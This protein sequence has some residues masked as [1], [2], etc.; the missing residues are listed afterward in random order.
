MKKFLALTA[1]VLGLASCQT[2]PEGLDVNVGGEQLVTVNV[3]VPETET[4]ANAGS[5]SAVGAFANGVLG[6]ADD[7][8]TMRYIL[9]VYYK[10]EENSEAKYTASQ[11]RLVEYS[12]GKTV[13]F[14]VRLVPKRNYQ[15][16]VWADVVSD[17]KNDT[18][19]HYNTSDLKNITLKGEWNAMDESR[20]AFTA[21]ELIENYS[22]SSDINITLKR[23]FAKLRVVTTDMKALNNLGIEPT[24]ATVEYKVQHY[25]A[26]NALYGKAISDS[27]NRDIKHENYTIASYGENIAE[28]AD[29]TL[30]SDYFFAENDAVQFELKVYDQNGD[31]IKENA[32]NTDIYV[33]RNYLTTIKGNILT[34][35]N[36]FDVT[37]D[38]VFAGELGEEDGKKFANVDTAE[39]LLDAI[40]KGIENITVED[41]IDLNDLL[42]AGTLA[43]RAT[44]DPS[45]AIKA[46]KKI[47]IDLGGFTLSATSSQTGKNYDMIDVRGTLSIKN[48]TIE[49]KHEGNNMEWN[50]STNVFNV[51]A[52]GVLNLD[53]VTAKN[54]GGSDMAFVAHLNNW[55]E[56]TL[57]VDNSTLESTYVAVRVF[58]SGNDMNNVTIKN[59]TL[60]G[61]SAAFWVHNYTVADFGS[62]AK[63]E[64][65]KALLNLNIY[66]QGNTFIPDVNGIRYGFTNSVRSDACGITKSVSEDGSIV[67]LGTILE[68]AV[69]RQGV[70]GYENSTIKK[71][72]VGEGIA[73]LE[74]RC[75]RKFHALEEVV[76]PAGLTTIG[77]KEKG[78]GD[79]TG[80]GMFQGCENL[81]TIIIPETVTTIDAGSFYGC[82]AL[83][84]INIPSGVTRI[85]ESS[86]RATGLKNIVFHEGV[87]YFG[88]QAFR[89]CENLEEIYINAPS[90]TIESNTFLNA[91]APYPSITIYVVNAEMKAYLESVFD[92]N[93][94]TF[95][96]V[97]APEVVANKDEIKEA[98]ES[99]L[100]SGD[101]NVIID[102]NGANIGNLDSGLSA[103]KIPAGTTVTI[104]NAN[105]SGKSYGNG[106]NGTVIFEGCTFNNSGAYSIH[107]DN[108]S[109]DVIFKN[110]HL[111]GWNSFGS[112]L[113]SVTFENCTLE[114]NGSYALIRSY[115]TL[116][117]TNCT[118][119]V[120]NANHTDVYPEGVEAVNDATLTMTN[121]KY[122]ASNAN[123][124]NYALAAG[125]NEVTLLAGNYELSGLNFVANDVTLKGVDK[126]NV[127]LN[128]ENSI[129]LQNKSV[130]LENLTYNL[131]AGKVYTEQA[132]AFVHHATAFNL[133]NCNV[134]RLRL[135]VNEANIEGCT[136]TLDTSNGF[137]GYCIYYYGND[138]ST[139]NVKN[140]TFATAGKGICIYSE[141]AKA[142]NLNVDKC[143]FTSSDSATD[144]A[145]IQMHTELGIYG[146]VKITETTATGF[147][148]ING[149]LWNELN[150]NTKVAT[151]KFDIW[152]DGT[153]VH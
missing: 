74:N 137:D 90:F 55:G 86:L 112:S 136:F 16:V 128:L 9:Q 45:L 142:Y 119:D 101:T 54:L 103:S 97:K 99:A 56:V 70:A 107:F 150:N 31:L 73:V 28:G 40:N 126:A 53:S 38:D 7:N 135:N 22:G 4:R 106:V 41:D 8:T 82:S 46:G 152:V 125:A 10:T 34:E 92:A 122:E 13:N 17:G 100:E 57:N 36:S 102:A 83:E 95:I 1:L 104:R 50:N 148:D 130:T 32:F 14:E 18:D 11:E 118:I 39:E 26:F 75:F 68:D 105:V 110:C 58:N 30:F 24:T 59:S 67:T 51:T 19:N 47:N 131:N 120:S 89:D 12:D 62:E 132:F 96:T 116:T 123:G 2:E 98:L 72:V 71:V 23:P 115:V 138:N 15:F 76:L 153:Q 44:T 25:N 27:K 6:T 139:V 33:K 127:V 65:Q 121:T 78:N 129:Y 146:N 49:C 85:E 63:A 140:S 151:D 20:D 48:G 37:I 29:M 93:T 3:T 134:N 88:K 42:T 149:G 109:G 124:L 81:K 5:D 79:T 87:T 108:G 69:L 114:G 143:S 117:L 77:V 145:A 66:D 91:A 52:G 61:V 60:Q 147:A 43:T 144:K 141:S 113:N 80:T 133:K 64:T 111:Y 84:T 35:N 94:K 21:T